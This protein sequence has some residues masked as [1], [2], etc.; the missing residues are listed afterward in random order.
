MFFHNYCCL[1][2]IKK[3]SEFTEY[4][5]VFRMNYMHSKGVLSCSF[6][7]Y[8]FSKVFFLRNKCIK[9]CYSTSI[10]TAIQPLQE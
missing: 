6:K 1:E 8:C 9:G 5:C 7:F 10:E 2:F 3:C 4:L